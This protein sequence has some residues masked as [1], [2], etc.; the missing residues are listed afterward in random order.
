[1]AMPSAG[2]EV[3]LQL[4]DE[5][6]EVGAGFVNRKEFLASCANR[7]T[8]SWSSQ[9]QPLANPDKLILDREEFVTFINSTSAS[10]PRKLKKY[11]PKPGEPVNTSQEEQLQA[12]I[13]EMRSQAE[14][15]LNR[16]I[17]Q[18]RA[19]KLRE[20][21]MEMVEKERKM[22]QELQNKQAQQMKQAKPIKKV[23]SPQ[24]AQPTQIDSADVVGSLSNSV[25]GQLEEL[26]QSLVANETQRQALHKYEQQV[27]AYY[28]RR[29]AHL[30]HHEPES[31]LGH[32][33]D[34]ETD[35]S[36]GLS[37]V[38]TVRVSCLSVASTG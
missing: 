10:G 31:V 13:Q 4:F 38:S 28:K 11:E 15:N 18:L 36:A 35:P 9:L 29:Y 2:P 20:L 32:N 7:Q 14:R 34:V 17:E 12:Q 16:E 19:Q 33:W 23:E 5:F 8:K 24:P 26:R 37:P 3:W 22:M 21:Q 25:A 1:V 30:K 6:D 27:E